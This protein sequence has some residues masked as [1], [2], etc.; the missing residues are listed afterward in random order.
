MLGASLFKLGAATVLVTILSSALS[1][2]AI[3]I[4]VLA[5]FGA[6]QHWKRN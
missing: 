4:L 2:A 5:L 3:I 6:W 1:L